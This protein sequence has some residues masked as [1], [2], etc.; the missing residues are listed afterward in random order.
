MYLISAPDVHACKQ[1]L[2]VKDLVGTAPIT[3][4]LSQIPMSEDLRMSAGINLIR[5]IKLI[6]F[7]KVFS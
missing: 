4:I 3:L 1:F 2:R 5:A 6:N 7:G